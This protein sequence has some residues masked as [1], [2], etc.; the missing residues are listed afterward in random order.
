MF[1]GGG[2]GISLSPRYALSQSNTSGF[3]ESLMPSNVRPARP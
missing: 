1:H 3:M 2:P